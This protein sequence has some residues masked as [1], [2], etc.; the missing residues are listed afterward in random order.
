[1]P[2]PLSI[3]ISYAHAD[4]A[5]KDRLLSEL[6]ILQ[7]NGLIKA[8]DDWQVDGG[9]ACSP[10]KLQAMDGCDLA[11]LLM[12]RDFLRAK[13]IQ[14]VELAH[15]LGRGKT[16]NIRVVPIILSHC[17]WTE[18]PAIGQLQPLPKH[19]KPLKSFPEEL[20]NRDE[21]WISIGIEI[22]EWARS[23]M[24][25]QIPAA[26]GRV[27]PPS[28]SGALGAISSIASTTSTRGSNPYDPWT[29]ATPPRFFGRADELQALH[30][31]LDERRSMSIIGERRIGKSSLLKTWQ[32]EVE[33]MHRQVRF[34]SG[35]GP[36]AA[37]CTAFVAAVT[38]TQAIEGG[39]L[40]Q[41]ADYAA[42]ILANWCKTHVPLLP[43]I[44]IDEADPL[45][46]RLPHRF[47]ERL[48]NLVENQQLCLVFAS[49]EDI[50]EVYQKT[51]RTS[52]LINLLEAKQLGLLTREA[53]KM[54][55]SLGRFGSHK[56]FLMRNLAGTHPYY[57]ALLGRRLWDMGDMADTAPAL[58][59]FQ[60]EADKRLAE[61][62]AHLSLGEQTALA[63]IAQGVVPASRKRVERLKM[64]GLLLDDM[65][66]FGEVLAEWLRDRE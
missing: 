51:G 14:S 5:D 30:R 11:L 37:S 1:M 13:F 31:A 3:F 35:Q 54:M 17:L 39:N 6:S 49:N 18:V 22:A 59:Q 44:L 24:Q 64:K 48:R 20:G 27:L 55:V 52:P 58:A 23:F 21:A 42:T 60:Y 50:N 65:Q 2:T 53:A 45:P 43:L 63:Q 8:W 38:G 15:L 36:E 12:S 57:L 62:W 33:A 28:M 25:A 10:E 19:A 9:E 7:R 47:F 61:L 56:R 66:L 4:E 16:D 40:D 46:Q 32:G 34:L 41:S 29:A 26:T